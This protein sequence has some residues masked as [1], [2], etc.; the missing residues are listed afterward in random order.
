MVSLRRIACVAR[1]ILLACRDTHVA[2]DKDPGGAPAAYDYLNC[3]FRRIHLRAAGPLRPQYAWG[4]ARGVPGEESR[5]SAH[6]R[7]FGVA[8]GQGLIC[9][10]NA[11]AL[12]EQAL[13][14]TIDVYGFDTGIGLP[15]PVDWQDSPS[16]SQRAG[17]RWTYRPS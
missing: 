7:R 10:E 6:F 9:L 8:G 3:V 13:E 5:L 11:A 4:A 2:L 17:I 12:V 14:L 1:R 16:T 15:A